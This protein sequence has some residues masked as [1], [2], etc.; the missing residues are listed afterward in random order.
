M[1]ELAD[2][3]DCFH[4]YRMKF[5]LR[6]DPFTSQVLTDSGKGGEKPT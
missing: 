3:S 6:E 2:V 5:D 1:I 4:R